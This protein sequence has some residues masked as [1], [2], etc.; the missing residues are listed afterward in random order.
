MFLGFAP[1]LAIVLL[2]VTLVNAMTAMSDVLSQILVQLNV[3]NELRGRAMGSWLVAVG[4]GPVGHIQL[5]ALVSVFGVAVALTS[6]GLALVALAVGITF[7]LPRMR[8]L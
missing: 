5:G 2:A 3:R 8:R 4:T 7:F 6:H 1:N